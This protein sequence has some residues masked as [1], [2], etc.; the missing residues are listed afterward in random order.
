MLEEARRLLGVDRHATKAEVKQAYRRL[1]QAQ[2]PDRG[3]ARIDDAV[4]EELQKSLNLART[5]LLDEFDRL[6]TAPATAPAAPPVSPSPPPR[7]PPPRAPPRAGVDEYREIRFPFLTLLRGGLT[8]IAT[9]RPSGPQQT[10]VEVPTGCGL[11]TLLH[12]LGAGGPGSP[13]GDLF[14]R[15]TDVEVEQEPIWRFAGPY[16]GRP[17]DVVTQLNVSFAAL[18]AERLVSVRTPWETSALGLPLRFPNFGPYRIRGHGV[19]RHGVAGD[20]LVFLEVVWPPR[21]HADLA[22]LLTR[23]QG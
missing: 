19:R 12:V 15:V 6:A 14:L 23:I 1:T 17:I 16:E 8:W 20:L 9:P 18:Y 13:P 22:G 2:H 4:R 7:P 11:G 5:T 3:A 21:G 10:Q